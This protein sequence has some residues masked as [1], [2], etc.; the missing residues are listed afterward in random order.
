[1]YDA[2]CIANEFIR[3]TNEQGY[4]PTHMQLQKLVYFAHARLLALH[5]E[6]LVKQGFE[7]WEY[8]PV[9]PELYHVLKHNQSNRICEE[10]QVDTPVY[11]SRERDIF[12]WCFKRYGTKSGP[13]LS[14]LTHVP[15]APWANAVDNNDDLISND[16][17]GDYYIVEWSKESL[18]ELHR[19]HNIPA[20]RQSV[21][22]SLEQSEFSEGY[23][24]DQLKAEMDSHGIHSA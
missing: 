17:I 12:D 23:S 3:R 19:I 1:M 14:R 18:A 8:G 22:E 11:S 9:V 10:I 13:E 5:R 21:L 6:P 15:Y 4:G 16:A 20:I 7:A 2:M 24:L